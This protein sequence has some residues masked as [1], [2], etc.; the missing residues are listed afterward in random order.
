VEQNKFQGR[1]PTEKLVNTL[2]PVTLKRVMGPDDY[3]LQSGGTIKHPPAH[4]GGT[5][6]ASIPFTKVRTPSLQPPLAVH[7]VKATQ[8][9]PSPSFE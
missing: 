5:A 6:V 7:A 2:D 9:C 1:H 4:L 8:T 3:K